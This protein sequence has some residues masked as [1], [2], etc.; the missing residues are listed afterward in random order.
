MTAFEAGALITA[1]GA[2]VTDL[3]AARIP[4]AITM[5]SVVAGVVAH[6]L[7]PAGSGSGT[8]LLGATGGLLV[9]LP[10]FLLGGMGGGDVKLMAALGAWLGAPAVLLVA[11]D[12]ALAGGV[13]AVA[14]ALRWG[15]LKTALGNLGRLARFWVTTGLRAEPSL[16]LET[17]SGPRLPYAVP[18]LAGLLLS[19]WRR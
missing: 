12:S 1:I 14:V 3:T 19:L 13:M 15:Y 10:F 4:N 7:L 18:V 2:C 9:F 16:T 5:T 11:L 8:S 6:S 17:G